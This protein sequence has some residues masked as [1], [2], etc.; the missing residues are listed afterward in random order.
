M[1]KVIFQHKDEDN[2]PANM[3]AL[4][5]FNYLFISCHA[6]LFF[7]EDGLTE[8]LSQS[9]QNDEEVPLI[10]GPLKA[11]S[12]S[13]RPSLSVEVWPDCFHIWLEIHVS[14]CAVRG[15]YGLLHC[16]HDINAAWQLEID[17]DWS[18]PLHLSVF[19]SLHVI[20]PGFFK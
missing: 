17:T 13:V 8:M 4:Y 7:F 12:Y 3:L 19:M 2:L 1:E 5:L 6:S 16:L 11:E 9:A 14:R 18:A 15:Q 20:H 10:F